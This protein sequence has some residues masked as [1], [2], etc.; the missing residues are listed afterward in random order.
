MI[1]RMTAI[2]S[3][4]LDA[5]N[6]FLAHS[7]TFAHAE[8]TQI[9][10]SIT[11]LGAITGSIPSLLPSLTIPTAFILP[12]AQIV[13]PLLC[14]VIFMLYCKVYKE[15]GD[16]WK[17]HGRFMDVGG[18]ERLVGFGE[19]PVEEGG[20]Y[21]FSRGDNYNNDNYGVVNDNRGD[22]GGG[23][24]YNDDDDDDDDKTNIKSSTTTPTQ[25]PAHKPYEA[26]TGISLSSPYI[27]C[28]IVISIMQEIPITIIEYH[29]K[30][31]LVS[32]N[33]NNSDGSESS[34]IPFF[35][36]NNM[37]GDAAVL[38]N[39][40]LPRHRASDEET[41][42]HNLGVWGISVNIATIVLTLLYF[43]KLYKVF[44]VYK[45]VM[46]YPVVQIMCIGIVLT[47]SSIRGTFYCL[48]ILKVASYS[49]Q[50]PIKE[51]LY[52]PCNIKTKFVG[53]IVIDVAGGR[54]AKG[55]ANLFCAVIG[56]FARRNTV[57]AY[58]YF[59]VIA[60]LP[61]ALS[62]LAMLAASHEIGKM[63]ETWNEAK[64]SKREIYGLEKEMKSG[65]IQL[66]EY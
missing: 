14:Y 49:V 56:Y 35:N 2:S 32:N 65:G 46:I 27:K 53:K 23:V 11:N 13:I 3:V 54:L 59:Q 22:N 26:K 40:T 57:N 66:K 39:S 31:L 24:D 9:I 17:T 41:I 44:K 12:V 60:T 47:H 37:S 15:Q 25:Q 28:M 52:M 38:A 16:V 34:H 29:F 21:N 1:A 19:D 7:P 43:L 45:T 62:G 10:N 6:V 50:D 42:Q 8:H 63:L 20:V 36:N 30:Q 58:K 61:C 51:L 33:N 5:A 55:V 18:E 48:T 64:K 4:K